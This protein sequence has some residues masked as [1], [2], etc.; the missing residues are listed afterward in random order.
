M[1]SSRTGFS[2]E[3]APVNISEL[4]TDVVDALYIHVAQALASL[5]NVTVLPY[6]KNMAGVHSMADARHELTNYV[7]DGTANRLNFVI[8]PAIPAVG[9][10][11]ERH[12]VQVDPDKGHVLVEKEYTD[13]P[14][15][16]RKL[17]DKV[18]DWCAVAI[19]GLDFWRRDS[20]DQAK[21][22][23]DVA[24]A[25]GF[26]V[27]LED[28]KITGSLLSGTVIWQRLRQP[29]VKV[30]FSYGNYGSHQRSHITL[31]ANGPEGT[32]LKDI[33]EVG[34]A[35]VQ[36]Q[37]NALPKSPVHD[38]YIYNM[39]E[40]VRTTLTKLAAEKNHTGCHFNVQVGRVS[41][42]SQVQV[43]IFATTNMC[44]TTAMATYP[45]LLPPPSDKVI[46]RIIHDMV[47]R[48]V[49]RVIKMNTTVVQLAYDDARI[50]FI[51]QL[52]L[53]NP[54]I[55]RL[56]ENHR[57]EPRVVG[58]NFAIAGPLPFIGAETTLVTAWSKLAPAPQHSTEEVA[59]EF[60]ATPIILGSMVDITMVSGIFKRF[61][62]LLISD[63]TTAILAK[64]MNGAVING[65]NVLP[66]HQV[67]NVW[68]ANRIAVA[69]RGDDKVNSIAFKR[70][71]VLSDG[72]GGLNVFVS[73]VIRYAD[74][75]YVSDYDFHVS[76]EKLNA[77]WQVTKVA[78]E[79]DMTLKMD[80]C[81]DN[82]VV[83]VIT[84]P[85]TRRGHISYHGKVPTAKKV[86]QVLGL[87]PEKYTVKIRREEN[88]IFADVVSVTSGRRRQIVP[89][90]KCEKNTQ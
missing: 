87:D 24:A 68:S 26:T 32:K 21:L 63:E 44:G 90:V 85:K 10:R 37:V 35:E 39:A 82:L 59:R 15:D 23:V 51:V 29:A 43:A 72:N 64:A 22:I 52:I 17:L 2:I 60:P 78:T 11:P 45:I 18:H 27:E 20:V 36:K 81:K 7:G 86:A 75:D 74:I 4:D 33:I 65:M 56:W 79:A 83:H 53:G 88:G 54:I 55:Q 73:V 28:F 3:I 89:M 57:F 5:G 66:V 19:Y 80:E 47:V 46:A 58:Y 41:G 49:D 31:A 40:M 84:V 14:L 42:Q 6:R 1:N 71:D 50:P 77:A 62:G 13:S 12:S 69:I 48:H 38:E 67:F 16:N 61:E 8:S 76:K 30:E 34:M 25:D 70:R 9:M